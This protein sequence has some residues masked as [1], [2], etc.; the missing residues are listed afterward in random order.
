M[1]HDKVDVKGYIELQRVHRIPFH[2]L[3]ITKTAIVTVVFARTTRGRKANGLVPSW[4]YVIYIRTYVHMC[5]L[6]SEGHESEIG[7]GSFGIARISLARSRS[8]SLLLI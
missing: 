6:L 7:E 5:I 1:S 8:E 2:T 3:G 4:F